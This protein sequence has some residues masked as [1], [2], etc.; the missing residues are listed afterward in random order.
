MY[1]RTTAIT[2]LYQTI[3]TIHNMFKE[4]PKVLLSMLFLSL[5]VSLRVK[6]EEEAFRLSISRS[7]LF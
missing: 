4:S 6:Q 5:L 3:R 7:I 1:R 2:V